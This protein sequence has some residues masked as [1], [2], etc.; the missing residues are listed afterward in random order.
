MAKLIAVIL[1]LGLFALSQAL[2]RRGLWPT[3]IVGG[4][5]ADR[6]EFPFQVS[7]RYFGSHLCGGSVLSRNLI[8]TAAHCAEVGNAASFT[9]VAGDLDRSV[10]EG[11][12]QTKQVS[13]VEI[14][15][16]YDDWFLTNDIALMFLQEPLNLDN[17]VQPIPL[18][19]PQHLATGAAVIS[20]WGT[21]SEGDDDGPNV[22]QKVTVP[23]ISDDECRVAYGDD[24]VFDHMICAG[25]PEGGKDSCQGD[26][27]GPMTATDLG[28]RYLAGIVSW[29]Y[30]CARPGYPGVY[31]EVSHFIEWINS[32]V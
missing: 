31:T 2:P 28:T 10:N 6:G 9:V 24:E 4:E 3:R 19:A 14:H 8:L 13:R 11:S 15:E 1:V 7:L 17:F 23:I 5:N 22:L 32:K 29:G 21:L 18:S 27:G 12:E 16:G 26:S 20:G 25:V 30:G